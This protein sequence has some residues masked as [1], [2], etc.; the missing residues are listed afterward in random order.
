[1]TD[2]IDTLWRRE[3]YWPFYGKAARVHERY[4]GIVEDRIEI[5]MRI[6]IGRLWFEAKYKITVGAR[7]NKKVLDALADEG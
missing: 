1:M 4:H 6:R 5:E 7:T 3:W 2:G